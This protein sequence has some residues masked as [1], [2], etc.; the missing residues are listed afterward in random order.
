[1][2]RHRRRIWTY[3]IAPAA[4]S[5]IDWMSR[6]RGFCPGIGGVHALLEHFEENGISACDDAHRVLSCGS[7]FLVNVTTKSYR[8]LIFP[9]RNDTPL[10]AFFLVRPGNLNGVLLR[11]IPYDSFGSLK[12][13]W[14]SVT[15]I[16][17]QRYQMA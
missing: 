15:E 8:D 17:V 3:E 13:G 16:L 11:L 5:D 14:R 2:K 10:L 6:V 4:R 9:N 1:M 7:L 12:E